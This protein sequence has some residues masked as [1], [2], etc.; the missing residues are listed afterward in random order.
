MSLA[1]G[2]SVP[3]SAGSYQSVILR[4]HGLGMMGLCL[5]WQ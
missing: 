4:T 1:Q 3:L 5:Q 2:P